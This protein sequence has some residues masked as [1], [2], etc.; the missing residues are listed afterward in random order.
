MIHGSCADY[1]AAA[2]ID[3]A[4]DSADIERKVTCPTLVCYGAAGAM[5][6]LFDIPAQW[7]QR[8]TDVAE[9]AL[10]GGHF[11]V[12]QFPGETA[13]ILRDFLRHHPI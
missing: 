13:E 12:D 10:P 9:A 7:R 6:K 11:F 4:H 8:C 5:A 3:L 1:R 2:S